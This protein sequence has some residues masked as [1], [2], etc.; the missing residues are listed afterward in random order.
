[1]VRFLSPS[2]L[3]FF[4]HQHTR[5]AG[6]TV[7][8]RYAATSG[9]A[10]YA[11]FSTTPSPCRRTTFEGMSSSFFISQPSGPPRPSVETRYREPQR[12]PCRRRAGY[13]SM[14]PSFFRELGASSQRQRS[15][16]PLGR[17]ESDEISPEA[18]SGLSTRVR[19]LS[20]I[21][22]P[23]VCPSVTRYLAPGMDF[24][25][26]SGRRRLFFCLSP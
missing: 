8:M 18:V 10:Y 3:L 20:S 12:F 23:S 4:S 6:L 5:L 25:R 13:P 1:M 22:H 17:G 19:A 26:A 15:R 7:R 11:V 14:A 2:S 16:D 21:R 9:T 24:R